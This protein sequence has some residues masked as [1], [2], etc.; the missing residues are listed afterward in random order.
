MGKERAARLHCQVEK[1]HK[2]EL[3]CKSGT[4]WQ[5]QHRIRTQRKSSTRES[6]K[7]KTQN[8]V[9]AAV[10]VLGNEE[11][12]GLNNGKVGLIKK[13]EWSTIYDSSAWAA[14]HSSRKE[15]KKKKKK[16]PA[17]SFNANMLWELA[18][19]FTISIAIILKS[20][21]SCITR[22]AEK[23]QSPVQERHKGRPQPCNPKQQIRREW[24]TGPV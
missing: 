9:N 8:W 21:E 12:S 13:G 17:S 24:Q 15:Y 7:W 2:I 16:N 11:T 19:K 14:E 1:R 22:E 4:A 23:Q 20:V 10:K 18:N 5:K 6:R 3:V